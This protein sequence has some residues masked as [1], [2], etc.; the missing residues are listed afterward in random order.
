[1]GLDRGS[2]P[3]CTLFWKC[4]LDWLED[5]EK[6]DVGGV[7]NL[8]KS[9][10][11]DWVHAELIVFEIAEKLWDKEIVLRNPGYYDF[12]QSRVLR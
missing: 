2:N 9:R 5:W 12:A 11:L 3:E 1:V 8:Q 6:V 4:D 7:F 10:P